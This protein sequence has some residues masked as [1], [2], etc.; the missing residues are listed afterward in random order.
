[1]N[2]Y[3]VLLILFA[4]AGWVAAIW[5]GFWFV[6]VK[7]QRDQF[8]SLTDAAQKTAE[9]ALALATRLHAFINERMTAAQIQELIEMPP[10]QLQN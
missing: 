3:L 9:E 2:P 5:F 7:R 4:I 10:D 1:M 6:V 8:R